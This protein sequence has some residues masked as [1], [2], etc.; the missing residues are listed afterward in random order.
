MSF[1]QV[2]MQKVYTFLCVHLLLKSFKIILASFV[3]VIINVKV[4]H[5]PS[6]RLACTY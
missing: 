4:S 6:V 2:L 1:I 3:L 5:L